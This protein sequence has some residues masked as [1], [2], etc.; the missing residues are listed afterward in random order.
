VSPPGTKSPGVAE[1]SAFARVVST[2]VIHDGAAS[3]PAFAARLAIP[4]SLDIA[5]AG[6]GEPAPAGDLAQPAAASPDTM[7]RTHAS[8]AAPRAGGRHRMHDLS[9]LHASWTVTA[10]GRLHAAHPP[11][12]RRRH[13]MTGQEFAVRKRQ[14]GTLWNRSCRRRTCQASA[15][16][17]VSG[18]QGPST[19]REHRLRSPSSLS[20]KSLRS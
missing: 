19:R 1:V 9:S 17:L 8:A 4:V 3:P 2:A 16:V 5:G 14:S 20:L 15:V 10:S 11:A 13:V 7:A 12:S 18:I 6:T